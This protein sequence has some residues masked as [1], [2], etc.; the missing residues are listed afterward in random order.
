ML[1]K[2]EC[3]GLVYCEANAYGMP[4]I[5]EA[6]GGVPTIIRNDENGLLFPVDTDVALYA[7][8]IQKLFTDNSKYREMGCSAL[9]HFQ[10]RLNW[11]VAGREIKNCLEAL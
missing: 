5:G 3:Y 10:K 1:S 4:V 9:K 7:N 6:T 11:D 2:A 8:T